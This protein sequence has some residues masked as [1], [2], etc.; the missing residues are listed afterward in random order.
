M[1][2]GMKRTIN[3][4]TRVGLALAPITLLLTTTTASVG[5]GGIVTPPPPTPAIQT[6][7]SAVWVELGGQ[8]R[9][10]ST[11]SLPAFTAENSQYELEGFQ[12]V[13]LETDIDVTTR[14]FV[15]IWHEASPEALGFAEA[16]HLSVDLPIGNLQA[17]VAA[18][19]ALGYRLA[20][21]NVYSLAGVE[22]FAAV[23]HPS[24]A[25]Q[26]YVVGVDLETLFAFK[27]DFEQLDLHLIDI[28][29]Y[30]MAGEARYAAVWREHPHAQSAVLIGPSIWPAV[31]D[32]NVGLRASRH[33]DSLTIVEVDSVGNETKWLASGLWR[34]QPGRSQAMVQKTWQEIEAKHGALI[35]EP[36]S[37]PGLG[38][39]PVD[40]EILWHDDSP[41]FKSSVPVEHDGPMIPPLDP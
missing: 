37:V 34:P 3:R 1:P 27:H 24:V 31:L 23:F 17:V 11:S 26:A 13:E 5:G 29:A 32:A 21:L 10:A 36:P 9:I 19:S 7:H 8:S 33:I 30:G 6:A 40:I 28:E 39:V 35:A 22:T 16:A 12:L 38:W 18:E 25:E 4:A 20:D 15:G 14:R 41:L 2:R